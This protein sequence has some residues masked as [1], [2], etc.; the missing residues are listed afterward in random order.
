M[1][2]CFFLLVPI[3][4]IKVIDFYWWSVFRVCFLCIRSIL[5]KKIVK[6]YNESIFFCIIGRVMSAGTSMCP[7][8]KTAIHGCFPLGCECFLWQFLLFLY[9]KSAPNTKEAPPEHS[10]TKKNKCLLGVVV[11]SYGGGCVSTLKPSLL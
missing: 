4:C 11:L 9:Q 7:D 1:F 6:L 5:H 8:I 3:Y 2:S 10:A